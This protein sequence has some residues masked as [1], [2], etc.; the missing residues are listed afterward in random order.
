MGDFHEYY[1]GQKTA[2]YLTLFIGGNHEASNYLSELYY[3]GWAAPNIYYTGAAN[4]IRFGPLRIA[5]LSGIWKRSSYNKPHAEELPYDADD[6][7]TV[8]HVREWDVRKLLQVSTQVD[9]C[10]SHDWPEEVELGGDVDHLFRCKP[11]FAQSASIGNLGSPPAREILDQLRPRY[12]FSG[13]MHVKFTAV[14]DHTGRETQ[15]TSQIQA[16]A[17]QQSDN[18]T[19]NLTEQAPNKERHPKDLHRPYLNEKISNNRTEFLALDKCESLA[20]KNFLELVE[21]TAQGPKEFERPF[22]LEYDVEWLAITRVFASLIPNGDPSGHPIGSLPNDKGEAFYYKLIQ[23]QLD[24]ISKNVDP[25]KLRIPENFTP[26][27]SI[28][29]SVKVSNMSADAQNKFYPN[30]QTQQFCDLLNIPNAFA[31][32]DDEIS[33]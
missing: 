14:I 19:I 27:A 12:W 28:S 24:W 17:S 7:R 6:L 20:S 11:H 31:D 4:V 5:G 26:T 10:L 32:N 1:S 3:G 13:H 22:K 33:M 2:P 15:P 8:Y 25:D 21:I 18:K 30:P 16:D 29:S 9:I 23:K